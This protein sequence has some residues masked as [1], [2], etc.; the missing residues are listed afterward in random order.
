MILIAAHIVV[1]IFIAIYESSIY[2]RDLS[3]KQI[4]MYKFKLFASAIRSHLLFSNKS[5]IITNPKVLRSNRSARNIY[6]NESLRPRLNF[7]STF[8]DSLKK[9]NLVLALAFHTDPKYFAVFCGSLNKYVKSNIKAVIFVNSP[10]PS[11]YY[12]IIQEL[13]SESTSGIDHSGPSSGMIELISVDVQELKPVIICSFIFLFSHF[14]IYAIVR[15]NYNIIS[16]YKF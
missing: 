14:L 11:M 7:V 4:G 2:S 6:S 10:V 8:Q 12:R 9:L 5:L 1:V 16:M 13:E 15:L 3:L